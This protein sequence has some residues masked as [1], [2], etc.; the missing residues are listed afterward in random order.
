MYTRIM[1]C[2]RYGFPVGPMSLLDEVGVD[3]GIS[4]Q[5]NLKGDLGVRVGTADPA[6]M[7][8]VLPTHPHT[9]MHMHMHMHTLMQLPCP[10]AHLCDCISELHFLPLPRRYDISLRLQALCAGHR[11]FRCRLTST[12]PFGR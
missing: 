5:K 4:V 11:G 12:H 8:K 9:H 7:E 1:R 2:G 10:S 6:V 3:V